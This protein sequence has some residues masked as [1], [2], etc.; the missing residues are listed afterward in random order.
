MQ[1]W[2]EVTDFVKSKYAK[3]C[4]NKYTLFVGKNY[5]VEENDIS[6]Y[7]YKE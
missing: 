2:I 3:V 1:I 5:Q 6:M 7:Y 4:V